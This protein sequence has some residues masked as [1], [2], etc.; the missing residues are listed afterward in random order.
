LLG[1][2]SSGNGVF[3]VLLV[4]L[5]EQLEEAD[6]ADEDRYEESAFERRGGG[7]AGADPAGGKKVVLN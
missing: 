1:R 6:S 3:S 5:V 4:V 7:N 2:K